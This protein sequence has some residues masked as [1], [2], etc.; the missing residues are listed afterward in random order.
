MSR[1][2]PSFRVPC[3]TIKKRTG[4]HESTIREYL[5]AGLIDEL[6]LYMAPAL[7]GDPARGMFELSTPLRNLGNKVGL[8]F[9]NVER[10]GGDLRVIARVSETKVV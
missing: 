7:I 9:H 8:S 2:A 6:L 1:R 4:A 5:N 3:S 10:V